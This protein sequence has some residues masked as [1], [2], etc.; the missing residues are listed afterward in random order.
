M[1]NELIIYNL[2]IIMSATITKATQKQEPILLG[3]NK[4]VTE[5]EEQ[6][7]MRMRVYESAIA[8]GKK[9]EQAIVLSKLFKNAYYMGC[10][11][12]EEA[13]SASRKYWPKEALLNPLFE[14]KGE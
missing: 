13:L 1:I 6:Y 9:P 7:K 5:T 10:E 12:P 4:D 14:A 11:Y 3:F 2:L 8:D